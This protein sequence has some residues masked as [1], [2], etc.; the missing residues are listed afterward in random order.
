[1]AGRD[2]CSCSGCSELATVQLELRPFCVPHFI[3]TAYARLD[4]CSRAVA[5][6]QF[7]EASAESAWVLLVECIERAADLTQTAEALDNLQRARLLDIL[8]VSAE[9]SRHLRRSP[10]KTVT[11]A[12]RLRCDKLGRSWE[13]EA[14]TRVLSRHGAMLDCEHSAEAGDL[15][16]V[17]RLDTHEEVKA[18]VAWQRPGS[19]GGQELGIEFLS[20]DNFWG[21]KWD[22]AEHSVDQRD[23]S[24][25][26]P[27]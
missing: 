12:V 9:L 7:Q 25:K 14:A 24:F 5:D 1:M 22:T 20:A 16:T 4:E 21:L 13:G 3:D 18:R 11:V 26:P 10:R 8:L 19:R 27:A 15:L 23:W 2:P 6:H 17:V